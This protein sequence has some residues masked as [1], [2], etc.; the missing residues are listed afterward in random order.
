MTDLQASEHFVW[1]LR[2]SC[3]SQNLPGHQELLLAFPSFSVYSLPTLFDESLLNT[4]LY[5]P[6]VHNLPRFS[7][8]EQK[9]YVNGGLWLSQS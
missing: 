9:A 6:N 5:Y 8:Y 4:N 2:F 3:E 1:T 7:A